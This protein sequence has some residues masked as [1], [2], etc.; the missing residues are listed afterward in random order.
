MTDD[1]FCRAEI[2]YPIYFLAGLALSRVL[3][4]SNG[5]KE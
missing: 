4:P 2:Y 3:D 1:L 5:A